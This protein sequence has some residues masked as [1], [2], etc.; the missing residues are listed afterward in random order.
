MIQASGVLFQVYH[1]GMYGAQ[2]QW[3]VPGWYSENWLQVDDTP[4]SLEELHQAAEYAITITDVKQD[5][6]GQRSISGQVYDSYQRR[7]A[8][9]Q[10]PN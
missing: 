2:Y 3:I 7:Y 8:L 5:V 10:R 4:C 1:Q 9:K 6:S